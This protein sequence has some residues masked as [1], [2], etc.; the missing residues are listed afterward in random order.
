MFTIDPGN[1]IEVILM[2]SGIFAAVFLTLRFIVYRSGDYYYFNPSDYNK[3][4]NKTNVP[5]SS[6]KAT[7]DPLMKQYFGLAKIMMTLCA[8]SIAFGGINPTAIGLY[9][10]KMFLACSIC[11]NLLFC[12]SCLKFYE[13]YTHDYKTYT[14]VRISLVETFGLSSIFYFFIGYGLWA[15][16]LEPGH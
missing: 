5:H 7:F 1:T 15:I 10:A 8:A 12:L 6:E 4:A 14:P 11:T 16:Y 9:R 3:Y 13:D 2:C